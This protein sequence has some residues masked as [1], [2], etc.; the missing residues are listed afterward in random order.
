MVF[1]F[2]TGL[3]MVDGHPGGTSGWPGCMEKRHDILRKASPNHEETDRYPLTGS[4]PM[5]PQAIM[6]SGWVDLRRD[7]VWTVPADV[8]ERYR[9]WMGTGSA[10]RNSTEDPVL[11]VL[12][13]NTRQCKDIKE[14][15]ILAGK[16]HKTLQSNNIID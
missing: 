9:T 13:S 1:K 2:T 12:S 11:F 14:G 10:Q 16:V 6:G 5:E 8:E 3:R 15:T 7:S 4:L